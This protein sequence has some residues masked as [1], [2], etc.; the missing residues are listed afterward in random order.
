MF[1]AKKRVEY[2]YWLLNL[3]KKTH[4][5]SSKAQQLKNIK[6]DVLK[7]YELVMGSCIISQKLQRKEVTEDWK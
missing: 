1:T 5:K 2:R 7:K 6:Y 3:E 4:G